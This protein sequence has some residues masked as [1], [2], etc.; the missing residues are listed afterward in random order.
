MA[1][2][3][4]QK[5]LDFA[6]HT[7][8]HPRQRDIQLRLDG[9]GDTG[10]VVHQLGEAG[11]TAF[12]IA[13]VV[14]R[15]QHVL[16]PDQ[17]AQFTV[18]VVALGQRGGDLQRI[19]QGQH[20][21]R[22][23]PDIGQYAAPERHQPA[24]PRILEHEEAR[25]TE[26]ILHRLDGAVVEFLCPGAVEPARIDRLPVIPARRGRRQQLAVQRIDPLGFEIAQF[27]ERVR[28]HHGGRLVA[29]QDVQ[30]PG[31]GRRAGPVHA[32]HHDRDAG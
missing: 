28:I 5:G 1:Q 3:V 20:K 25:G 10:P 27:V 14:F 13:G 6:D 2:P 30:N 31:Q 26:F 32:K 23:H 12:L 19:A 16:Q 18:D 21:A 4:S 15:L 24:D 29:S 17:H 9:F 7:H 11:E 22:R 8:R